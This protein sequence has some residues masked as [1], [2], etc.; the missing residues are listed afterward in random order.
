MPKRWRFGGDIEYRSQ[1][2]PISPIALIVSRR[3]IAD[4]GRRFSLCGFFF[5]REAFSISNVL[6]YDSRRR[7]PGRAGAHD[8]SAYGAIL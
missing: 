3:Q 5:S 7:L 4:D 2:A 6:M 1:S 8:A